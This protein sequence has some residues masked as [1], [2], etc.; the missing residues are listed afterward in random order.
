[1]EILKEDYLNKVI[2]YTILNKKLGSAKFMVGVLIILC[3]AEIIYSYI[4]MINYI[5]NLFRSEM[6]FEINF[7][8]FI[9]FIMTIRILFLIILRYLIGKIS[10]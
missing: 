10:N 8:F 2:D 1:M 7:G 4:L 5:K 9:I 6:I 3:I